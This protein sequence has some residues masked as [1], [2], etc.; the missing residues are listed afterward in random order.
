MGDTEGQSMHISRRTL[1][2]SFLGALVAT[3]SFPG[4]GFGA[5]RPLLSGVLNRME[6]ESLLSTRPQKHPGIQLQMNDHGG[7][8]YKHR[9][10]VARPAGHLNSTGCFIWSC[11]DGIQSPEKIAERVYRR[12]EVSQ[13]RAWT[14]T[15]AFLQRLRRMGALA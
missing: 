9:Q 4:R 1:L 11:C 5:T 15:M 3:W 12:Y 8:L 7:V 14:D 2:S 6:L 10:G 13:M